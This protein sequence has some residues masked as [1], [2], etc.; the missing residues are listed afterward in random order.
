ASSVRTMPCGR[1]QKA[2]SRTNTSTSP[3]AA[4]STSC[5]NATA[6]GA[7]GVAASPWSGTSAGRRRWCWT[8]DAPATTCPAPGVATTPATRSA[9]R[10]STSEAECRQHLVGEQIEAAP[11]RLG[12]DAAEQRRQPPTC[13]SARGD[14]VRVARSAHPA[15]QVR[16]GVELHAV[17]PAP[18]GAVIAD[19]AV[20]SGDAHAAFFVQ[21]VQV[22]AVRMPYSS[23]HVSVSLHIPAQQSLH[24]L[25]VVFLI[26]RERH[27]GLGRRLQPELHF[28]HVE[29]VL[30]EDV[31]DD[32][33]LRDAAERVVEAQ[34]DLL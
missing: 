7:S 17:Q 13:A 15:A 1:R 9:S 22:A 8:V 26:R 19:L 25:E 30:V 12:R 21:L 32:A 5:A 3:G 24:P 23:G 28:L 2:R 29:A 27:R 34:L 20:A 33:Q 10:S 14:P 6:S 18:V 16:V 11:S 31:A 4:T